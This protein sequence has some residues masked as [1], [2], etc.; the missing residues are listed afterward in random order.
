MTNTTSGVCRCHHHKIIPALVVLIGL[1]FLL[2]SLN[3]LTGSAV[4]IIWPVLVIVG[5][6]SKMFG[7]TCGCCAARPSDTAHN[8]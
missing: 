2:G 1:T 8:G 6:L 4:S 3:I 7:R 5:G